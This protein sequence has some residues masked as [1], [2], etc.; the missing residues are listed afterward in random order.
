MFDLP[1]HLWI[2]ITALGSAGLTLPLAL[3][4]AVWLALGYS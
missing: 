1:S 4:V 3:T 2:S